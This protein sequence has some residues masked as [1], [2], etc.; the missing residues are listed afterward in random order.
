MSQVHVKF[1]GN[2][3]KDFYLLINEV[4]DVLL[5]PSAPMPHHL[6][7]IKE[8]DIYMRAALQLLD[9]K[10]LV[11]SSAN[12][13]HH[14][15][16]PQDV[17]SSSAKPPHD[18]NYMHDVIR[19]GYLK[20]GARSGSM[21]IPGSGAHWKRK[22][23]EV[24]HGMFTYDDYY[25]GTI[26]IG[27]SDLEE[28]TRSDNYHRRS[29]K[30]NVDTCRCRMLPARDGSPE[31]KVFE[32]AIKDGVKRLWLASSV[33]ECREWVKAIN[34]AMV[35]GVYKTHDP[36]K[37]QPPRLVDEM[38]GFVRSSARSDASMDFFHLQHSGQDVEKII[39]ERN[40]SEDPS[41]ERGIGVGVGIGGGGGGSGGIGGV[42]VDQANVLWSSIDGAAAPYVVDMSTFLQLQEAFL[43]C[44]EESSYRHI[45]YSLYRDRT[46]LTIPVLFI[47]VRR[48]STPPFDSTALRP[49]WCAHFSHSLLCVVTGQNDPFEFHFVRTGHP[50]HAEHSVEVLVASVERSPT[51]HHRRQRGT[52]LGGTRRGEYAGCPG[53]SFERQ[54]R[55]PAPFARQAK[56]QRPTRLSQIPPFRRCR[57]EKGH[58]RHLLRRYRRS[59][60]CDHQQRHQ[61]RQ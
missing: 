41:D 51:R 28:L 46:R 52:D 19:L 16:G 57:V 22:Y 50:Q 20:K 61:Q 5:P 1:L 54:S 42:C 60:V 59:R 25:G 8:R 6:N 2:L 49:N 45:L 34:A 11:P 39:I 7:I 30:L 47:K 17:P 15:F 18:D 44:K 13:S 29:I 12:D 32:I 53:A 31:S 35:G 10:N 36:H 56:A 23:V 38:D 24:R 14:L 27:N 58:L 40:F 9:Q 43:S 21:N 55:C 3:Q 48:C 37:I 4:D 33:E 26:Y